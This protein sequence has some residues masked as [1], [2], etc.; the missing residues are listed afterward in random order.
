MYISPPIQINKIM[1]KFYTTV[2]IGSIPTSSSNT[3][4]VSNH[5]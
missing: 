1:T 4:P 3:K 2:Y 5:F